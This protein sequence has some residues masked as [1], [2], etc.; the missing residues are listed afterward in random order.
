MTGVAIDL[1]CWHL[2]RQFTSVYGTLY[3][4]EVAAV[5]LRISLAVLMMC[6]ELDH[7]HSAEGAMYSHRSCFIYTSDEFAGLVTCVVFVRGHEARACTSCP[8]DGEPLNKGL[9]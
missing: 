3:P 7:D 5:F 1:K 2:S 8:Q 6:K 9:D 4:S